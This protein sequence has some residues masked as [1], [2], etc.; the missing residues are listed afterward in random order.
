MMPGV[1]QSILKY[2]PAYVVTYGPTKL[3]VDFDL[4]NAIKIIS[5][6]IIYLIIV[7]LLS[8]LVYRR[9]VKKLNVNGG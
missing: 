5:A 1:L 8:N 3:I 4:M 9:G 6:Q 7:L 2:T